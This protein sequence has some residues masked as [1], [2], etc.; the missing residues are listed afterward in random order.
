MSRLQNNRTLVRFEAEVSASLLGID[1]DMIPNLDEFGCIS[2]QNNITLNQWLRMKNYDD[3]PD[4]IK[5][6][7]DYG[8]IFNRLKW[9]FKH[10]TLGQHYFWIVPKSFINLINDYHDYYDQLLGSAQYYKAKAKP[11]S[12]SRSLRDANTQLT[13]NNNNE[14]TIHTFNKGLSAFYFV[15]LPD[16]PADL[17]VYEAEPSKLR[18]MFQIFVSLEGYIGLYD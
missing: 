8:Y 18:N 17:V 10:Y 4:S 1:I 6:P 2:G 3:L 5:R 12:K 13:L 9:V 11:V 16:Q 15:E 14:Y 7:N